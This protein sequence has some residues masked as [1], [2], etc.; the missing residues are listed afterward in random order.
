MSTRQLHDGHSSSTELGGL[1]MAS[2]DLR[3]EFYDHIKLLE[4]SK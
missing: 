3:R 2:S 4:G 1:F